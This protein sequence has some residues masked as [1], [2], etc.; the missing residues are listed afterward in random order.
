MAPAAGGSHR[1]EGG[2]CRVGH[3][4][5]GAGRR[6]VVTNRVIGRTGC[7]SRAAAGSIPRSYRLVDRELLGLRIR[8][9]RAEVRPHARIVYPP[10]EEP[11]DEIRLEDV[12]VVPVG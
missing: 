8:V 11:A 12:A 7:G 6:A 2:G 3:G 10:C 5:R 9:R 4:I 1:P